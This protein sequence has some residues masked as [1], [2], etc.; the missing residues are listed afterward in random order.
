[1]VVAQALENQR[2][3]IDQLSALHQSTNALIDRTGDVLRQQTE[4]IQK[5]Q[6]TSAVDVAVLQRAFDNVFATMDSIETYRSEAV[7]RMAT[8]V[9]ALERQVARSRDYLRRSRPDGT[10]G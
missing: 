4:Q 8:T 2:Q 7:Q 10:G 9:D 5:E 1:M 6:T 3:V